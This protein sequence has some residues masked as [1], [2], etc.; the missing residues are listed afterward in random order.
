M[1]A[2]FLET[3]LLTDDV[4]KVLCDG[5]NRAEL[6]RN[7]PVQ[8]TLGRSVFHHL[9]TQMITSD[10][11]P[12]SWDHDA[13]VAIFCNC[14]VLSENTLPG[15]HACALSRFATSGISHNSCLDMGHS[16]SEGLRCRSEMAMKSLRINQMESHWAAEQVTERLRFT[17]ISNYIADHILASMSSSSEA[18]Y[19]VSVSWQNLDFNWRLAFRL[20][21]GARYTGSRLPT[22]PDIKL[23]KNKTMRA[24][25][26]RAWWAC[27]L[28][29]GPPFE[30]LCRRTTWPDYIISTSLG[31]ISDD[32]TA[33]FK[34]RFEESFSLITEQR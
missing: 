12:S 10:G 14:H 25:V 29:K 22:Y 5:T 33:P 1:R 11:S 6:F 9:Q 18:A 13:A 15:F 17:E 7:V 4:S 30:I 26:F 3:H 34:R 31:N 27:S 23:P 2:L 21:I 8:V 28:R 19:D 20:L 32:I 24:L 16:L